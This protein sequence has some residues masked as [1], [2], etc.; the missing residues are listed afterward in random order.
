MFDP[1]DP[2]AKHR[3]LDD[4]QFALDHFFVKL[5][6]V[7]DGMQTQAGRDMAKQRR[8]YLE[9]YVKQLLTEL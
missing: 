9:G 1:Y 7:A 2:L 8:K 5:Y 3:Q 4:M 6:K